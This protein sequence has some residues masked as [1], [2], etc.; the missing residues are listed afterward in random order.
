[1]IFI[2]IQ[3]LFCCGQLES[4]SVLLFLSQRNVW[5]AKG[6]TQCL[7]EDRSQAT[8]SELDFLARQ[9]W[10]VDVMAAEEAK[11]AEK[12]QAAE[13]QRL[14]LHRMSVKVSLLKLHRH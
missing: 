6:F 7:L 3:H 9:S 1:M 5:V 10:E 4:E 8:L 2:I 14:S 12:I 11:S 13:E